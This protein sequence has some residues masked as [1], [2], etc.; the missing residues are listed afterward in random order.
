[1]SRKKER[2]KIITDRLINEIRARNIKIAHIETNEENIK[3]LGKTLFIELSVHLTK[4]FTI[5]DMLELNFDLM[6]KYGTYDK[7]ILFFL[8]AD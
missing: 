7:K 2:D 1:M 8:H 3:E 4:N 6:K 5:N